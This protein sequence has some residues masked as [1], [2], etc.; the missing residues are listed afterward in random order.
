VPDCVLSTTSHPTHRSVLAPTALRAQPRP[1][2]GAYTRFVD[3]CGIG[4]RLQ[5]GCTDAFERQVGL[6]DVLCQL[7][8]HVPSF[9]RGE[10]LVE[11]KENARRRVD[12]DVSD[13]VVVLCEDH[14]IV[15]ASVPG[16]RLVAGPQP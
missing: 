5:P 1:V 6:A 2:S 3:T 4:G 14:S 16:N 15:R 8:D 11:L 10:R 13:K 7:V 9:T 12:I